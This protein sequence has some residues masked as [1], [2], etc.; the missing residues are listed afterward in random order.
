MARD[1]AGLEKLGAM[2]A[3]LHAFLD[4]WREARGTRIVPLRKAFD[5][6]SV[7]SLLSNIYIY[8]WDPDQGDYIC[9]LAGEVVNDAYGRRIKGDTL[10]GIVGLEDHQTIIDR[11]GRILGVPCIHYGSINESLSKRPMQRAERLL[12]PFESRPGLRDTI[13]GV[14]L[15]SERPSWPDQPPLMPSD[16]LQIPCADF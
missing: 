13:I 2:D 16:I 10:A 9:E 14:G 7:P 15:Y 12:L 11:W 1:T 3:R 5:P 4:A 8:K 6:L